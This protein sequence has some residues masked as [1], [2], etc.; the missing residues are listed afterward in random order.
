MEHLFTTYYKQGS[1]EHFEYAFDRIMF[2]LKFISGNRIH[3]FSVQTA[4][5]P[6]GE[7]RASLHSQQVE[8]RV[9]FY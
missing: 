9:P 6:P 1:D 2:P 8:V 4:K 7:D 5:V 3:S